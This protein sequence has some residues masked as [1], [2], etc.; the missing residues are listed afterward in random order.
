M[1][2]IRI[3]AEDFPEAVRRR[4]KTIPDAIMR[5]MVSGANRG[6]TI[7]VRRTPK[8]TGNAKAGWQVVP[9]GRTVE[10]RND[11]PYVGVLEH[12]ARPH[13]VSAEG[14]EAIAEWVRRKFMFTTTVF[15]GPGRGKSGPVQQKQSR[16]KKMHRDDPMVE[17]I[18]WGIVNKLKKYGQPPTYFVKT[19]I[20][21][22]ERALRREIRREIRKHAESRKPK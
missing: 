6:R 19:S 14:V 16:R 5:G 9:K 8:D 12:G 11:V 4:M 15:R 3:K 10:L 18:T 1:T 22:L 17:Q 2:V 20:P 13:P 7:L 21:R